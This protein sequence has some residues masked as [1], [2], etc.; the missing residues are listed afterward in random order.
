MAEVQHC[1]RCM[2]PVE[3]CVCGAGSPPRRRWF[4]VRFA[5]AWL[6]LLGGF[7]AGSLFSRQMRGRLRRFWA[8]NFRPGHVRRQLARRRGDCGQCGI[9]CT[10]GLTCPALKKA[11]ACSIYTTGCRP[12]NCEVFPLDEKDI[13]DVKLS[14]GTCTYRFEPEPPAGGGTD[15]R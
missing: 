7:F 6:V 1:Q 13:E 9:C 2:S 15:K 12:K 11:G 14:G 8:G 4:A 5:Q 10:L 3:H